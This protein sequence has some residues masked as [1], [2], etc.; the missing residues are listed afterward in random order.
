MNLIS[1][2][3]ISDLQY[4]NKVLQLKL[5]RANVRYSKSLEKI[6]TFLFYNRHTDRMVCTNLLEFL[7]N[8]HKILQ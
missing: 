2:V 5:K 8:Y 6:K 4:H 3:Q 7:K 1:A